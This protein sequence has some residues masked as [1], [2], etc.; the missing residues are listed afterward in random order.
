MVSWDVRSRR[1]HLATRKESKQAELLIHWRLVD[2]TNSLL[3]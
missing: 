2:S 3:T 1:T